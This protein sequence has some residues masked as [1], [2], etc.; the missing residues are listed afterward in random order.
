LR[1]KEEEFQKKALETGNYEPI[2]KF[3]SRNPASF[4]NGIILV[5]GFVLTGFKYIFAY[6]IPFV[7]SI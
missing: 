5:F 4:Y 2:G 3:D 1:L 6:L 7:N